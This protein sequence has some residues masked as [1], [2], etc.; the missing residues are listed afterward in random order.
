MAKHATKE[1]LAWL[2]PVGELDRASRLCALNT[3]ANPIG[4]ELRPLMWCSMFPLAG[5]AS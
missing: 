5:V 1:G 4:L 2:R 3:L